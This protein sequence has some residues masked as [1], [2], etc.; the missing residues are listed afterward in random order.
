MRSNSKSQK[1]EF[2]LITGAVAYRTRSDMTATRKNCLVAGSQNVLINEATDNEGDKVESRLGYTLKGSATPEGERNGIKSEFVFN[3]KR[4]DRIMMRFSKSGDLSFFSEDSGDWEVLLDGLLGDYPVRFTTWW[5]TTELLRECLFVNHTAGIYEWGGGIGTL[6]AITDATHI[7]INETITTQGFLTAGTRSIRIKDDTG[8]WRE[9]VYTGEAAGVFTVTTDLTGYSFTAGALVV[10]VVRTNANKPASGF[11]NDVIRTLENHVYVG[12]H[13]SSVVYMSK[14]TAFDDFTFS[15]PRLATDGWQFVMD[16][17]L[18]GF[19]T[20]IAGD[21]GKESMVFF[22]GNDWLYRVAFVDIA[23]ASI[24]QVASIKPIIVASGQG[25]ISQEL[26]A[27]V[28]NSIIYI[29]ASNE[30]LELGSVENITT[31]QQTPLSDPIKPD[32]LAADFTGGSIRFW[33][34][35]LY[36]FAA[37]SARTFILAFREDEKGTRRFWQPPQLL[38]VGLSS[39]YDG[40]LIGHS[41]TA[42]ESFTL[43]DG[44]TD[45]GLPISFKA[46]FAY[47]NHGARE[48]LKNFNLYFSELYMTAN[49]IVRHTLAFEYLAAKGTKTFEYLG[50]QT[51]FIFTPNPGASIGINNLGTSPLGIPLTVVPDFLKYRRF[52]KMVPLDYFEFQ[53][54]YECDEIDSQ[55]QIL[56]HG[57]NTTLSPNSP[58]KIT[59]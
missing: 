46:Y 44:T 8:V 37:A 5:S 42:E 29:N 47:N 40:N 39:D 43:F 14:S 21:S 20:N 50:S 58:V 4:G 56:C 7:T 57:P 6:A 1:Q 45:N 13:G 18:V 31:V 24:A 12:S 55:F 32:F 49:T 28:K 41:A 38:P 10:Q 27:K 53:S 23:D 34:N 2:D 25:A 19:E 3:T 26:I 33:R 17:F 48:K 16:D 52:K 54:Q 9:A 15:S 51:D 11:I 35:N 30:L 22:A 36:V 59:N